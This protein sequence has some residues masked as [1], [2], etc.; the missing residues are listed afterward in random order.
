MTDM[1]AFD[2]LY[3][4]VELDVERDVN[5]EEPMIAPSLIAWCIAE[6]G[7]KLV[8]LAAFVIAIALITNGLL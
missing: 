2:E 5:D 7:D 3:S 1:K 6:F 4:S 8:G